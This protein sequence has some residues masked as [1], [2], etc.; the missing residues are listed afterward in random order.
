NQIGRRLGFQSGTIARWVADVPFNG[1]SDESREE[2]LAARRDP[3]VYNRALELRQQG[4]SYN[5]I[6]KELGVAKSTLSNWLCD[7]PLPGDEKEAIIVRGKA[8]AAE[9][10]RRKYKAHREKVRAEAAEEFKAILAE[11]LTEREL[12]FLGL[13]LYWGEGA[14]TDGHQLS[15]SNS[16]PAMLQIF[17]L[18]LERFF[19]IDR[20]QLR[21]YIFIYPDIDIAEAENYWSEVI[22]IP[23]S[24]FYKAQIDT[25]EN[26]S[27]DKQ[28]KLKYGTVHLA[29]CGEGTTDRQRKIMV[30]IELLG[31]Y[32][33][34]KYAGIA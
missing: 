30:W 20:S 17:V 23:L 26:K 14:K 28:G 8:K 34:N 25:R 33:Q 6:S 27:V 19:N 32:I 18:W 13:M 12:V 29:A 31:E 9:A 16:D 4:W 24:Q 1:F 3:H 22:G 10:N 21:A 11:D 7:L 2:Q 5:M 15:V